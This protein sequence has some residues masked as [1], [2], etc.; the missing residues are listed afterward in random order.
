MLSVDFH[1]PEIKELDKR[2]KNMEHA[3]QK[4][5]LRSILQFSFNPMLAAVKALSPYSAFSNKSFTK[6]FRDSWQVHG[7]RVPMPTV[8]LGVKGKNPP[9]EIK[10]NTT[11]Y[12][13]S[14]YTR[15]WHNDGT[16]ER[17]TQDGRYTGKIT[18][19]S[20]TDIA[21]KTT[22]GEAMRRFTFKMKKVLEKL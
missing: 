1:I 10:G 12:A 19:T 6:S 15:Y 8:V 2:F 9:K 3:Q 14:A 13:S 11:I 5:L 20:F 18:G 17:Y 16:K 22:Q 7:Y 4:K 21:V